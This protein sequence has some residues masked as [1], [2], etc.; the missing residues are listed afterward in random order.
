MRFFQW[1]TGENLP[2][3]GAGTWNMGENGARADD[4]VEVLKLALG[5]GLTLID[6]AEMYGAGGAEKIVGRAVAGGRDEV[7]IVSKV[8]PHN[9]SAKGT[10]A[11]CE[12]SLV[13]LRVER[14]DLY[15]LHWRSSHPL[16]E[17]VRAFGKL[18]ADGKVAAWGVSNFDRDDMTELAGVPG[19]DRCAANQVLYN[20]AQRGIEFDL[21]PW[22]RERRIPVM[23]YCPLDQAGRMLRS[24][25]LQAVAKRH[26]ATP[27]QIA[28]AWLLRQPGVASIPK[29]SSENHVRENRAAADVALSDRD[30]AELDAAFP[31]PTRKT[32]LAMT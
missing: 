30:V 3:L 25:P 2:V 29:A 31:P 23:A 24:K 18:V 16:A 28:L 9:A 10:I 19:S 12:R 1:R 22:C 20:L 26:D 5:L 11:A 27:A 13:R 6:T 17:T 15:L 14:I 7:F 32:P 21:L 8:Y 4:E